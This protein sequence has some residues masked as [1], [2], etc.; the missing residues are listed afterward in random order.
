MAEAG[1]SS[2]LVGSHWGFRVCIQIHKRETVGSE[3]FGLSPPG[4]TSQVSKLLIGH[5][6]LSLNGGTFTS[7]EGL[8]SSVFL[9]D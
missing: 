5:G 8:C 7:G 9:T 4:I 2:L 3:A 6:Y 1:Q